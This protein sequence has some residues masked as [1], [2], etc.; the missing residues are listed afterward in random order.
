LLDKGASVTVRD[1]TGLNALDI[2]RSAGRAQMTA[3][4]Q[5]ASFKD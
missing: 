3:L 1:R 5:E 2:A 4:L